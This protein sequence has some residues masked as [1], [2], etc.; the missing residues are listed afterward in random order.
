MKI[1]RQETRTEKKQVGWEHSEV[2]ENW[3][4][5]NSFFHTIC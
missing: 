2:R 4:I 3:D 5:M 1:L